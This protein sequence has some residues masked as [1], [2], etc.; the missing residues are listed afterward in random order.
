MCTGGIPSNQALGAIEA[1]DAWARMGRGIQDV[2]DPI[3]QMW[4]N[5]GTPLQ[6]QQAA[7]FR[8][9]RAQ[10]EQLYMRGLL[11]R[12]PT[13]EDMKFKM[14]SDPWRMAGQGLP[15]ALLALAPAAAALTP[16]A[17]ASW[18]LTGSA[19][20]ALDRLARKSGLTE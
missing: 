18:M 15:T 6:Q 19:Y 20:E 8:R 11:G 16:E 14:N 9:Q 5:V 3:Q 10:D 2:V 7:A 4:L 12:V 1:P 13:P 17:L